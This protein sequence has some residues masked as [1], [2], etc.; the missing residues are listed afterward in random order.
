MKTP[1]PITP[2]EKPMYCETCFLVEY[3]PIALD[4]ETCSHCG[5]YLCALEEDDDE[6]EGHEA[7]LRAARAQ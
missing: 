2:E 1:R 6:P 3:D 4:L 7:V 5:G